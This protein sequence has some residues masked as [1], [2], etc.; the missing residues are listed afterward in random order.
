MQEQDLEYSFM[1]SIVICKTSGEYLL[2]LILDSEINPV[3][4][5]SFIGALSL[6]GKDNIGKIE[7][8]N[9]KGLD[10][11]MIIVSKYDL[12]LVAI[13]EREYVNENMRKEAEKSL[14]Y[15]YLLFKED[16][17]NSYYD[18]NVFE[19]F[20]KILFQ[21]IK[22]YSENFNGTKKLGEIRDL[23]FFNESIKKMESQSK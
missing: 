22:E 20:K 1:K 4:L 10:L 12:I 23:E 21:Q 18:I 8:I 9:I 6:F 13:M 17:E 16:I 19:S 15:F 2:D 14:E 11:E 5:S 7:E 3:L